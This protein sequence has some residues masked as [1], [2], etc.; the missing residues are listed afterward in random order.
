MPDTGT[1]VDESV[2][3]RDEECPGRAEPE[4]DMETWYYA[5][6]TCGF[7]FGYRIVKQ[8]AEG[9]CSLGVGEDVRRRFGPAEPVMLQIGRRPE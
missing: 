5:C 8:P 2:P 1:W 7:E 3:C 9:T 4:G 6:T